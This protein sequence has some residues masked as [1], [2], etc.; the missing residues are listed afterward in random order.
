MR[1]AEGVPAAGKARVG[2]DAISGGK[3]WA[4]AARSASGNHVRAPSQDTGGGS[5]AREFDSPGGRE[6]SCFHRIKTL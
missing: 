2:G 4:A 5:P 3:R 6:P 1:R